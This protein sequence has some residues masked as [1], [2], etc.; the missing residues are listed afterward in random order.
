M[1][2]AMSTE[3]A[4]EYFNEK[5]SHRFTSEDKTFTD[6]LQRPTIPPPVVPDYNGKRTQ[7]RRGGFN[8]N[9][10]GG[11][12]QGGG[13]QNYNRRDDGRDKRGRYDNR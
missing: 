10:Y 7:G 11:D 4:L 8:R 13:R 2:A 12:N 5:Y 3:E 6:A 9:Q 1:L